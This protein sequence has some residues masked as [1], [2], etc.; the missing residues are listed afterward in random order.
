MEVEGPDD[1][2]TNLRK[3]YGALDELEQCVGGRRFLNDPEL[4]RLLPE[5]GV[6]F[7][8]EPGEQRLQSGNGCRVVRVGTHAVR[9]GSRVQ[10]RG[11]LFQHWRGNCKASIFRLL[12]SEAL[13]QLQCELATETAQA[14]E[15]TVTEKILAMPF[16]WLDFDDAASR[17]SRRAYIEQNSI[18]LLSNYQHPDGMLDAP[19]TDWLGRHSPR[20][21][22]QRS[23]LWNNHYVRGRCDPDFPDCFQRIVEGACRDR[24]CRMPVDARQLRQG[25][26]IPITVGCRNVRIS[27]TGQFRCQLTGPARPDAV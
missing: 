2:L 27:A 15:H 16:V 1:R 26:V 18:A 7:F 9:A 24:P 17:N 10:L 12:I 11:R 20:Q 22:I 25:S 23:G 4:G 19:S 3:F 21:R 6:Y 13:L 8:F 5:R 14:I